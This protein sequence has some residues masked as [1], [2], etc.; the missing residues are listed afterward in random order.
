[1][2]QAHPFVITYD[3]EKY[4]FRKIVRTML[5]THDLTQLHKQKNYAVLDREHD[6]STH[7]HRLYYDHFGQFSP[8]YLQLLEEYVMP[9]FDLKKGTLVYQVIPTFRAQLVG[10]LS[11]GE[12][13]KDRAYN[14]DDAEINFWMPFTDTYDTN[15]LWLESEEDRGDF[16]PYPVEYG[17]ILVFRGA[18]L[19]HGNEINETPDSRVSVDFR[20][21]KLS[22]FHP[23]D[24]TS[25]NTGSKFSLG[26]YFSLM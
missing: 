11:V 15:T 18:V 12:W 10:N 24:K 22:D 1:M 3:T 16:K 25:I 7:W 5:G 6:Q 17:Q 19:T 14:H 23:T 21:L 13:H 9:L 8:L 26:G 20:L 4:D 2:N